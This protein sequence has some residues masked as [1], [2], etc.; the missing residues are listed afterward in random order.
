M[1][2]RVVT[3][4]AILVACVIFGLGV[5]IYTSRLQQNPVAPPSIQGLLWPNPRTLQNFTLVDQHNRNFTLTNLRGKW[6]FLFFGYTHCPDIC[7]VTLSVMNHV[8]QQLQK[9]GE[10][11]NVQM[12]FISVD[13]KRDTPDVIS[14]YVSYFN[15]DFIGLTGDDHQL[16]S[17]TGQMGIVHKTEPETAPG[18]Y[19]VDHSA[20]ILL[21]SPGGQ[22]VG[23]FSAPQQADDVVQRFRSIRDF[24][25][26]QS[27]S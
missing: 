18:E 19:L 27:R 2:N 15:R 12:I 1:K 20:A 5:G 9:H 13:P 4:A 23:L 11:G 16:E 10:S 24:I 6:S 21:I 17:L 7:P 8:Y 25:T 26:N 3:A 14:S 22:W